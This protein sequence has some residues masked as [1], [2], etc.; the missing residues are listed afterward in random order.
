MSFNDENPNENEAPKS[1]SEILQELL[2]MQREHR[3]EVAKLREEVNA[4]KRPVPN[5]PVAHKSADQL[6]EER[7]AEIRAHSHY[8]PDCGRLSTYMRECAGS[9]ADKPHPPRD[10][11]SVEELLGDDPS[12][13]TPA[14][15]TA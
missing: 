6:Y 15:V 14:T 10:M 4:S 9:S 5:V 8:C 2:Q 3:A 1:D 12:A 11:V 13:H 7:M